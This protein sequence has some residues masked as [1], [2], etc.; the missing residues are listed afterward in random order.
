MVMEG[1]ERIKLL[2]I[3]YWEI[4]KWVEYCRLL[5]FIYC[6]NKLIFGILFRVVIVS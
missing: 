4:V 1:V 2:L 6:N 3:K 5:V